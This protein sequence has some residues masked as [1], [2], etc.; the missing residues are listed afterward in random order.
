VEGKK[1]S[2]NKIAILQ[3]QIIKPILTK[4]QIEHW[5]KKW[6]STDLEDWEQKQKMVD[7]FV[8]SVYT[9]DDKVVIMF[10]H[11]EGEKTISLEELECSSVSSNGLPSAFG[12]M[13][14][15]F[16]IL[17]NLKE[18]ADCIGTFLFDIFTIF[19]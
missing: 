7:I 18:R 4:E 5:I 17:E 19:V 9:Y 14:K 1:M 10:N 12:K 13:Q 6:R 8:N 15:Y 16:C 11:K 2:N 3:G